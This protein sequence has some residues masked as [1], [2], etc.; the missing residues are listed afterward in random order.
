[1]YFPNWFNV[2][3]ITNWIEGPRNLFYQLEIQK[4]QNKK[5][6]KAV[7]HTIERSE[8]YVESILKQCLLL[9]RRN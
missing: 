6:I 7:K 4:S 2:K 3:V 8:W 5:V 1:M 9:W